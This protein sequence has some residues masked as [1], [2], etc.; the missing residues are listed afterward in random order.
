[1]A[2]RFLGANDFYDGLVWDGVTLRIVPKNTMWFD[3]VGA[4]YVGLDTN[5]SERK[6]ALYGFYGSYELPFKTTLDAY[7]FQHY[8]GFSFFHEDLPDSPRWFTMGARVAGT[9]EESLDF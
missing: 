4:R 3:I 8:G 5:A 9:V 6:P 1:M 2:R 7:F